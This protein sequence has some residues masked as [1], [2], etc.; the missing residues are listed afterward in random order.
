MPPVS[1]TV[2]PVVGGV[3][4]AAGL[5]VAKPGMTDELG[6]VAAGQWDQRRGIPG[7]AATGRALNICIPA[8]A[9]MRD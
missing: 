5:Q 1:G 6:L 8:L 3:P 9:G 2:A 4:T 7:T